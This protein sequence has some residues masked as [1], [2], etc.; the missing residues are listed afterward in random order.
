M[1]FPLD[2]SYYLKRYDNFFDEKF[3]STVVDK[4]KIL[5]WKSHEYF[6]KDQ[7][8][9]TYDDDL[10]ISYE[11]F[12]EKNIISAALTSVIQKYI[13]VDMPPSFSWFK[14]YNGY[15]NIR[16][17]KYDVGTQMRPHCDHIHDL[18]DGERK[19]VPILSIVGSL[20]NDYAGGDFIMWGNQK[21]EIP[22]GSIIVFPSNFMFPH[23]VTNVTAGTRYSF[24]SWVW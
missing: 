24:V 14:N 9:I 20:N 1:N 17:N 4:L 8:Y 13:F 12:E 15:S 11:N 21:I 6:T 18:F 3:C 23:C 10:K 5:E 2:V 22:A 7:E 16:F 19:G